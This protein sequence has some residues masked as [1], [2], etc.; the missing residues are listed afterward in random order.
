[1]ADRDTPPET[2]DLAEVVERRVKELLDG[3]T[4]AAPRPPAFELVF[5]PSARAR[6]DE[7]RERRIWFAERMNALGFSNGRIGLVLGVTKQR[8]EQLLKLGK[9]RR[10][11]AL[12]QE[13][14]QVRETV[15]KSRCVCLCAKRDHLNGKGACGCGRCP[16][17]FELGT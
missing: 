16:E 9:R 13:R 10:T 5:A 1:M 4:A 17:F 6:S 12:R 15:E 11:S 8:V 2:P 7:P 14:R 3:A